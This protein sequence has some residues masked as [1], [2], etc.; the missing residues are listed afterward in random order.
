M[1]TPLKTVREAL[2]TSLR[3]YYA[4]MPTPIDIIQAALTALTEAEAEMKRLQNEREDAL[5]ENKRLRGATEWRPTHKHI[6]HGSDYQLIGVALAKVDDD[7]MICDHDEVYIY[8]NQLG[9]MF[10]RPVDEFNDGRF[11]EIAEAKGEKE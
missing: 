4:D 1:T 9:T 2:E 10:M 11:E 5:Q 8:K 3:K 7:S 6:Q